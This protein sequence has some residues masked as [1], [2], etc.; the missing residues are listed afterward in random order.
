MA[1]HRYKRIKKKP[2]KKPVEIVDGRAMH[3]VC[4][5]G[6]QFGVDVY[7]ERVIKE[8][9]HGE[10]IH[11]TESFVISMDKLYEMLRHFTF[12]TQL[13]RT[14]KHVIEVKH[15]GVTSNG[16]VTEVD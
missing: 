10:T 7:I 2:N 15:K 5:K 4:A 11:K 8:K 14:R 3:N 16:V 13:A 6:G 9:L 1:A 12:K